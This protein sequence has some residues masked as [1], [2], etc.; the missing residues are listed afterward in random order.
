MATT[1]NVYFGPTG[2]LA[3]ISQEQAGVS[4]V[5]PYSLEYST[6]YTWRVDVDVDGDVT[7]GNTWTFTTMNKDP[8]DAGSDGKNNIVTLSRLVVATDNKIYYET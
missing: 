4:I 5:V 2:N 6:E 3:L 8:P 1:Y 7:T